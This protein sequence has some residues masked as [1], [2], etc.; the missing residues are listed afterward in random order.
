MVSW[1]QF[2]ANAPELAAF[3]QRRLESRIAYLATIRLDGSPRLHPVSPFIASG[4]LY[5]YMEPTS[6][7]G[8]D[9]R[10]DGRYAMHGGVEDNS[11]GQ[12]EFLIQGRAVEVSD[13]ETRAEA[14][15]QARER[16]YDPQERYIL[17]ELKVAEARASVYEC[18]KAKRESWK[19]A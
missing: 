6:P 16:G 11:G 5:V 10:R 17:F 1:S 3:G 2:S 12:G 19:A 8:H 9:L 4:K 7:K 15:A 14:F 13:T 18:G